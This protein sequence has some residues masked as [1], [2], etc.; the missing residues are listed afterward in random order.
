MYLREEGHFLIFYATGKTKLLVFY[1]KCNCY[2]YYKYF[3]LF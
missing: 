1:W 2:H 3:P